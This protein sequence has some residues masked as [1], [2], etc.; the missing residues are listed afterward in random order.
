MPVQKRQ[1]HKGRLYLSAFVL[2]LAAAYVLAALLLP[3]KVLSA[4][5]GIRQLHITT[6]QSNLPWP[7]Y[8]EG[9]MGLADGEVVQTHNRQVP[10]A[11]ASVAKLI[12]ALAVLHKYPLQLNQQGPSIVIDS[13]DYNYYTTYI[14]EQGS[15]VPVYTGEQLSELQM[16]EAM[17]VP[18][19]NNIADALARWAYGSL[20]AYSS[21][22]NAY[23]KQLGLNHTHIGSDASGF[24]PSTTSTARDLVVLGS[25]VIANPVLKQIVAMQSVN[26]PNVGV[27]NNYDSIIGKAGI[28]GIKTGNSNQA[29][30]VFLAAANTKVNSKPVTI[31]VALMGAPSLSQVLTD[32][33]PMVIAVE[34]DFAQTI[35]V[36]QSEVLDEFKLPWGGLVQVAVKKNLTVY[37]L[38]GQQLQ[39]SLKLSSLKL[40][41]AGGTVLGYLSTPANNLNPAQSVPVVTL[42]STSKPTWQWRLT[43]PKYIF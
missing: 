42:Q 16:L 3:I 27:M 41:T 19:G 14:A 13:T 8:G 28:I 17:L 37:V 33:I 32:T 11:T 35:L 25:I 1:R 18:S 24:S 10:L 21:F 9:A 4:G 22:A 38:Q 30:G 40:P 2:L 7:K 29:G 26:V 12:T 36:D 39:A 31:I 6:P 15:V 20:S 23:V 34:N 5:K 43:H